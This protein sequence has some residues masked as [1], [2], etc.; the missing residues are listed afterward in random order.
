MKDF[1]WE[2][3]REEVIEAEKSAIRLNY[4]VDLNLD[5]SIIMEFQNENNR[6]SRRK[7]FLTY[8]RYI[9][10]LKYKTEEIKTL[11]NSISQFLSSEYTHLF[12]AVNEDLSEL[13]LCFAAKAYKSTLIMAGSILETFLLD[14]LS[15]IDGK[16]YLEEP[17]MVL[18][19]DS[20]GREHW[21]KKEQLY[22][23][24]DQIKEIEK[25]DWMESSEKAHYIRNKRNLVHFKVCLKSEIEINEDICKKVIGYLRDIVNT[26]LDKVKQ[27]AETEL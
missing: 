17:Y 15:E 2:R 18:T 7:S 11:Y 20:S 27:I 8:F 25:P 16:D 13:D 6:Y 21:E 14:W 26:R 10:S 23:Y 19:R 22:V 4:S 5:D 12:K 1:D 24:I 3:I 9:S